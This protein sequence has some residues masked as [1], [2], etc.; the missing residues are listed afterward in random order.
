MSKTLFAASSIGLS[1]G[2]FST[3]TFGS[4]FSYS[5]SSTKSF[6]GMGTKTPPPPPPSPPP[7]VRFFFGSSFTSFFKA[8]AAPVLPPNFDQYNI[9]VYFL[10]PKIL[11]I[12]LD[13]TTHRLSKLVA[14]C[15]HFIFV[16]VNTHRLR[17]SSSIRSLS[18][19][20]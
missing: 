12:C 7:P 1:F 11:K 10:I 14:N 15:Y 20:K 18:F 9:S 3:G 6:I 2:L 16:W 4:S 19:C 13:K 8:G 17:R 5:S